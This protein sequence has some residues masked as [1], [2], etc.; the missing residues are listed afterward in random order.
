MWR[1]RAS[2]HGRRRLG[3]PAWRRQDVS[4]RRSIGGTRGL[5]GALSSPLT[6]LCCSV[7]KPGPVFAWNPRASEYPG[8]WSGGRPVAGLRTGVRV[9]RPAGR[10]GTSVGRDG[11]CRHCSAYTPQPHP[12]NSTSVVIFFLNGSISFI[13]FSPD[14]WLSI[15][16]RMNKNPPKICCVNSNASSQSLHTLMRVA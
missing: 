11:K 4:A 2:H 6:S 13:S 12:L 14:H 8:V 7:R 9:L 15:V 3:A 16:P 5:D 1:G 10:G